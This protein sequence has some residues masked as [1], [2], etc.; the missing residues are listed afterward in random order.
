MAVKMEVRDAVAVG[1]VVKSGVVIRGKRVG[2][3][4]VLAVGGKGVQRSSGDQLGG[5][6]VTKPSAGAVVWFGCGG[7]G[8][9]ERDCCA[10]RRS[11][12]GG[13]PPFR[14]GGCDGVGHVILLYPGN[15][16]WW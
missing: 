9:L 6:P 14:F 12:P 16:C 7:A 4:L 5:A 11:G 13:R 10:G 15:P 2:T 1:A 8:H 3:Q